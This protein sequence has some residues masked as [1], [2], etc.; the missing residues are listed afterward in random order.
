MS[1]PINQ[2]LESYIETQII[3]QYKNF[4]SA[5]QPSHAREVINESMRLAQ[6]H[7]V[8][9]DMVY[10]IAAYHDTGLRKGRAT[11]Q[12]ESGYII[13]HDKILRTFFTLSEIETM[14]Q[15]AED[16]RASSDH[17]PRSIY[18]MIVAEA[19]RCIDATTIVRR[20]IQYGLSHY[21]ECTKEEH[22][23]R[24]QQ[25]MKEKYAEGGYLKIWLNESS[26]AQRLY[27]FQQLLKDVRR[28]RALFE[29]QWDLTVDK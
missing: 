2:Q 1:Y 12:L 10:T 4:D 25:H 19:D 17:E 5:H 20:T 24:F 15:A 28:T 29:A 16:H 7:P 6:F 14:A 27:E 11:H 26:N 3:P 21:P 9:L 18:G 23:I 8:N 13:R 22:F